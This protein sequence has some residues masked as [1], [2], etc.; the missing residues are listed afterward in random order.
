MKIMRAADLL[1][2]LDD[3][4]FVPFRLHL[5]DGTALDIPQ[6]GMVIVGLSSA[7]LP[8]RFGA[9]EEGNRV[10]LDWRTIA[11][12]HIVQFS[13]LTPNGRSKRGKR[14]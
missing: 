12:A 9:D 10:A 13:Q 2:R 1:K 11:L 6:P 3:R 14:K 4:P 8:S 5:T 7:V